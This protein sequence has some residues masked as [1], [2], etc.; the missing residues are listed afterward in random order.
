MSAFTT[1]RKLLLVLPIFL[2]VFVLTNPAFSGI[3]DKNKTAVVIELDRKQLTYTELNAKI[4]LDFDDVVVQTNRIEA[5]P[6]VEVVRQNIRKDGKI[7]V[8]III[9]TEFFVYDQITQQNAADPVR[10]TLFDIEVITVDNISGVQSS[11]G[12]SH[13][14]NARILEIKPVIQI[15]N[16]PNESNSKPSP[17]ESSNR[18]DDES[19]SLKPKQT[20]EMLSQQFVLYPNPVQSGQLSLKGFGD[21]TYVSSIKIFNA[22]G[23][24]VKNIPV[25]F[26]QNGTVQANVSD[27][28]SGIYFLRMNT[29][30]GEIVKR[31]NVQQ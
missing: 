31:F 15:E 25:Q 6:G 27:L 4:Q 21:D 18:T 29:T 7:D 30:Q 22:L 16:K 26:I 3:E 13:F 20:R 14:V 5:F 12:G 17:S 9:K 19:S 8:D 24:F 1:F 10:I 2:L 23:V 28:P 11:E